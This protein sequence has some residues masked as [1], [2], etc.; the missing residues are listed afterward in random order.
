MTDATHS[1]SRIKTL[2]IA[3]G[4]GASAISQLAAALMGSGRS[5]G[6]LIS[7]SGF[8]F[9]YIPGFPV[10]AYQGRKPLAPVYAPRPSNR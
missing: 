5:R 7:V 9:P 6:G 8:F 1:A 2:R 10:L 3:V 4:P